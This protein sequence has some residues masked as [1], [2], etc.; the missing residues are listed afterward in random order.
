MWLFGPNPWG[1]IRGSMEHRSR[2]ISCKTFFVIWLGSLDMAETGFWPLIQ[3]PR[4][5]ISCKLTK[6]TSERSRN[7]NNPADDNQ[8]IHPKR[9]Q[10]VS[11]K[12]HHEMPP[13]WTP[14]KSSPQ[15][16][17]FNMNKQLNG[18]FG[19]T[20]FKSIKIPSCSFYHLGTN[21]STLLH[22]NQI[23]KQLLKALRCSTLF[24]QS[25]GP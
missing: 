18:T 19:T 11:L 1:L 3:P 2:N 24:I 5:P 23:I 9:N 21:P 8:M 4:T 14:K 6:S 12:V 17:G 22:F 20:A 16:F 25:N 13:L 15:L 7:E 10:R